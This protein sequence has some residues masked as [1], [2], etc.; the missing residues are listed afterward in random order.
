MKV[1]IGTHNPGK[2]QEFKALLNQYHIEV[3]TVS[4]FPVQTIEVEETGCSY[5]ENA[6]IK[7]KK[8]FEVYRVPVISD[9]SGLEVICLDGVPGLKSSRFLAAQASYIAKRKALIELIGAKIPA[10]AAFVAC[11]VYFD[12][13][14][15]IE[16]SGRVSGLIIGE[17]R[18]TNGFGYDP[19]F[20]LPEYQLTMAEINNQL[21]NT[22]S[23]R[24]RACEALIKKILSLRSE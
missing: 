7:A 18:G 3:L 5:L 4:D 14:H 17:E 9:D 16:A 8:Y 22:I 6:T 19:I 13:I 21:K 10:E 2:I 11:L 23:H 24:A 12:G 20:Y 1:L 15:L